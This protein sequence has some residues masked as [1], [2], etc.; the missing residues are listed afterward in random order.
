LRVGQARR[1][2]ELLD[3]LLVGGDYGD[4]EHIDCDAGNGTADNP[5]TRNGELT[6]N[7]SSLS[8]GYVEASY[9]ALVR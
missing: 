4:L 6:V 9:L 2:H 3:R 5:S 7:V 1:R 8:D